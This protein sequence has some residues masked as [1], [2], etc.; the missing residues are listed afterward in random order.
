MLYLATFIPI[1]WK[2]WVDQRFALSRSLRRSS[3]RTGGDKIYINHYLKHLRCELGSCC[4]LR[5]TPIISSRV[6]LRQRSVPTF[7]AYSTPWKLSRCH[8]DNSVYLIFFSLPWRGNGCSSSHEPW[9]LELLFSIGLEKKMS[10]RRRNWYAIGNLLLRCC[11]NSICI[12][13][14]SW[15]L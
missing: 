8:F 6:P 9:L 14:I 5:S 10:R 3:K 13:L 1:L 2:H 12:V 7:R 11:R 15:D 4:C